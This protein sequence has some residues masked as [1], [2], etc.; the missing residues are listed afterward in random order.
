MQGDNLIWL[1]IGNNGEP[2]RTRHCT[3]GSHKP[4][5]QWI[6]PTCGLIYKHGSMDDGVLCAGN[7]C[8]ADATFTWEPIWSY[9][10]LK[11]LIS[12]TSVPADGCT[13]CVHL[14]M[15]YE[16]SILLFLQEVTCTPSQ[17]R[18]LILFYVHNRT[19]FISASDIIFRVSLHFYFCNSLHYW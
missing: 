7:G 17:S 8:D 16:K 15:K 10:L 1:E 6:N 9:I 11:I 4:Y 12:W 3:S 13:W 14:W 2:L 5:S 19:I 18:R